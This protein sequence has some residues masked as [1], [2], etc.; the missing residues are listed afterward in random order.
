MVSTFRAYQLARLHGLARLHDRSTSISGKPLVMRLMINDIVK[1]IHDGR[2][3]VLRVVYANSAGSLA[4]AEHE[5][6][7]VDKRARSKEYSYVFKT[8]G[9]LQKSHGRKVSIS[10]IGELNDPGF[11]D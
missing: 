1:L 7:N 8:A 5:Q 10:P 2:V 3:R 6:A 4:L 9:S 11:K